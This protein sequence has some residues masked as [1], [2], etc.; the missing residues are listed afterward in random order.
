MCPHGECSRLAVGFGAAAD[1][2]DDEGVLGFFGEAD[3]VVSDAEPDLRIPGK[4]NAIPG[5]S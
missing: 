2:V 1:G 4:L 5:Q 3:A